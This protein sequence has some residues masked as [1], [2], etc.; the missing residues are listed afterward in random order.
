MIQS[1]AAQ[2]CGIENGDIADLTP[3]YRS[4]RRTVGGRVIAY[5]RPDE[6]ATA[7][8]VTAEAEKNVVTTA[9]VQLK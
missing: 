7:F 4:L 8:T 2:L 1:L 3:Y 6:G 9:T 5:F